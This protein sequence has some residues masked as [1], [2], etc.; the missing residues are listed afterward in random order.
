MSLFTVVVKTVGHG[1]VEAHADTQRAEDF[2][3]PQV[4]PDRDRDDLEDA[5]GVRPATPFRVPPGLI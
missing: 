4:D 2:G 1:V 5:A 3:L